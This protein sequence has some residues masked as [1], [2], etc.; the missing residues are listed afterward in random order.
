MREKLANAKELVPASFSQSEKVSYPLTHAAIEM[1][2][3]IHAWQVYSA[4]L[5][6]L[7]VTAQL[8]LSFPA[9]GYGRARIAENIQVHVTL[10]T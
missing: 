4:V 9:T 2:E 5:F 6:S 7:I 3:T 8:L 1:A 10:R